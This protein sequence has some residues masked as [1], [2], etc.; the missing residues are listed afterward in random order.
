MN[1]SLNR[2][3]F[4]INRSNTWKRLLSSTSEQPLKFPSSSNMGKIFPQKLIEI[5]DQIEKLTL[6]EVSELNLLL[7]QRLN[8]PDTPMIAM[9][10][11]P[12]MNQALTQ[13]VIFFF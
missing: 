7:K 9:G 4:L 1:S 6:L 5:V 3:R 8:I 12:L 10:S 2:I 11:M 13:E